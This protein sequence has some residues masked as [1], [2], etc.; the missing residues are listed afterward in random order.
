VWRRWR[1]QK[2]NS[3]HNLPMTPYALVRAGFSRQPDIL[4]AVE[5]RRAFALSRR[6]RG[7]DSVGARDQVIWPGLILK[8]VSQHVLDSTWARGQG[9]KNFAAATYCAAQHPP[10]SRTDTGD[11]TAVRPN[12]LQ[13]RSHQPRQ[14]GHVSEA[15]PVRKPGIG[16]LG[17][18]P[19]PACRAGG[20]QLTQSISARAAAG[21]KSQH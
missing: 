17:R 13:S 19:L 21:R 12:R 20:I 5:K 15:G 18:P 2:G 1:V 16:G 4:E 8:S 6:Q 10:T 3:Q 7:F 11:S 14:D 9:R